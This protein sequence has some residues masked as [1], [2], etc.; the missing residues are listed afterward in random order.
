[1]YAAKSLFLLVPSSSWFVW[2]CLGSG[3]Q[4]APRR[5]NMVWD[6]LFFWKRFQTVHETFQDGSKTAP[7]R[8]Q[9]AQI[10]H[11]DASKT[12]TWSLQKPDIRSR[13][14]NCSRAMK[15]SRSGNGFAPGIR[16]ASKRPS[17]GHKNQYSVQSEKCFARNENNTF[18]SHT[19]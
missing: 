10:P 4:D 9:D 19:P 15:M 2:K 18:W 16:N 12:A 13:S 7:R 3:L 17:G 11:Q 6:V 1:M 5:F 8:P 14:K